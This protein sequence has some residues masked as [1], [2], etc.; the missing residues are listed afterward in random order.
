[1]RAEPEGFR[2]H[3][4]RAE[5]PA[6]P[7]PTVTVREIPDGPP[8]TLETLKVM[9]RFVKAARTDPNIIQAAIDITYPLSGKDWVGVIQRV[10]EYVRDDIRY[11]HDPVDVEKVQSPDLTIAIG[12]GDCDDKSVLS[13]ALLEAL[14]HPVR[15]V[16]LR[17]DGHANFSHVLTYTR[18]GPRWVGLECT[19]PWPL[20]Q[21]PPHA[22]KMWV[23]P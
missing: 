19:E 21:V 9:A 5:F 12:A 14:G 20:G 10:H 17:F 18:I 3:L 13:G 1:M 2:L 11:I 6:L 16:A 4:S 15:L 8:G 23:K 22:E 7:P